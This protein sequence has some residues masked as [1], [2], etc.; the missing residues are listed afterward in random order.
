MMVENFFFLLIT[1]MSVISNKGKFSD[2]NC[3]KKKEQHDL[4]IL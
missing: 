2:F 4:L 1:A 3:L